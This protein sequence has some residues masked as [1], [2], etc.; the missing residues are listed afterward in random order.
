MSETITAEPPRVTQSQIDTMVKV[1]ARLYRGSGS[2]L[3]GI[4]S[5]YKI[6]N[7]VGK[8]DKVAAHAAIDAF[9]D[10]ESQKRDEYKA[11]LATKSPELPA[12][13]N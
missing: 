2:T 9:I 13:Q 10:K 12:T 7:A 1:F 8:L 6:L 11:S 4:G 3:I 5:D